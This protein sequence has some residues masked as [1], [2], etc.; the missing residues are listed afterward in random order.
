MS[1]QSTH[2]PGITGRAAAARA[3]DAVGTLADDGVAAAGSVRRT[4]R[5]GAGR[6]YGATWP[7]GD[8]CAIWGACFA[9]GLATKDCNRLCDRIV[10]ICLATMCLLTGFMVRED[11][12]CQR[13]VM[14]P[15]AD[16]G[17][18]RAIPRPG[19]HDLV[20]A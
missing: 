4:D 9:K 15:G 7:Y 20:A 3:G 12:H 10:T 17:W 1:I 11:H 14:R 6:A 19:A 13:D 18:Y 5:A 16:P 8:I 2:Q